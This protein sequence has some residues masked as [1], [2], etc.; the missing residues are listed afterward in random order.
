MGQERIYNY[1]FLMKHFERKGAR[2]GVFLLV[3]EILLI[4]D[5]YLPLQILGP[6][7]ILFKK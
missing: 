6:Y 7:I 4:F 2:K 3:P 5:L 1:N